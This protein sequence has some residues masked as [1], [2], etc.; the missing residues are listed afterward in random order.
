MDV[1]QILAAYGFQALTLRVTNTVVENN[2]GEQQ[3]I[4]SS[5]YVEAGRTTTIKYA[6]I[7]NPFN[8][9]IA[10]LQLIERR[11]LWELMLIKV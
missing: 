10:G 5:S 6:V 1:N 3:N 7:G 2:S 8:K 11:G 9:I 4:P